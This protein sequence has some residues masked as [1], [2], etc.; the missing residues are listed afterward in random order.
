MGNKQIDNRQV[1]W[2]YVVL[3]SSH[4]FKGDQKNHKEWMNERYLMIE[5]MMI[6]EK[7]PSSIINAASFWIVATI[8]SVLKTL[9][10]GK[11]FSVL[12]RSHAQTFRTLTLTQNKKKPSHR[13]SS[14]AH[15]QVIQNIL[16]RDTVAFGNVCN[17]LG[18]KPALAV[19]ESHLTATTARALRQHARHAKSVHPLH[20]MARRQCQ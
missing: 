3:L 10:G 8:W 6:M 5:S 1:V 15:E 20:A 9:R 19:D 12:Q 17:L 18:T 13:K 7:G 4:M 16:F 2:R 11:H 14:P